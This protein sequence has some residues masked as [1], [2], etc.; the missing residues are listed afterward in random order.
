MKQK[1][2]FVLSL[3]LPAEKSSRTKHVKLE[4]IILNAC[5]SEVVRLNLR[6]YSSS[7]FFPCG[8]ILLK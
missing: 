1:L 3:T 7:S 8:K 6:L 5:C 2:K 4:I